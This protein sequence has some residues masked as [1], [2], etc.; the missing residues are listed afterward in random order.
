VTELGRAAVMF[1]PGSGAKTAR[2]HVALIADPRS[3]STPFGSPQPD[4]WAEA[5]GE[6]DMFEMVN[7]DK[8]EPKDR[9]LLLMKIGAFVVAL[10][11]LGG[12]VYFMA[13]ASAH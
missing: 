7:E 4:G 2:S 13:F 1:S 10:A 5:R 6:V 3:C 9:K 12:I 8:A 11:A